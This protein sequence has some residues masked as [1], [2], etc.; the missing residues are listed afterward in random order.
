MKMDD[1]DFLRLSTAEF[2]RGLVV[3]LGIAGGVGACAGYS[4]A[5]TG[6][7]AAPRRPC[8]EIIKNLADEDGYWLECDP[9]QHLEAVAMG[10]RPVA[11]CRCPRELMDGGTDA[12]A[13]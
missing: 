4:C 9:G 12:A 11:M 13:P 1:D 3:L 6:A 8:K 2:F 5:S 10:G 7:P